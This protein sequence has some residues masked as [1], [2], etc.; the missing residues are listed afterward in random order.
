[1]NIGILMVFKIRT[2]VIVMKQYCDILRPD[3]VVIFPD[4]GVTGGFAIASIFFAPHSAAR[5]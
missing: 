5:V 4:A 1:M 3:R 2:A